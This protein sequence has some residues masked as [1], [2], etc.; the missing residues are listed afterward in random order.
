[1][2][3]YDKTC[4]YGRAAIT[5]CSRLQHNLI[6]RELQRN[7]LFFQS[8]Y[9]YTPCFCYSLLYSVTFCCVLPILLRL[10]KGGHFS[11]GYHGK[12][13][14]SLKIGQNDHDNHRN[15]GNHSNHSELCLSI[16]VPLPC[17]TVTPFHPRWPET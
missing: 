3:Y 13:F 8:R 15:H 4:G 17:A 1:M 16:P 7:T 11:D 10:K 12:F 9:G 2:A 14:D 6:D 5:K